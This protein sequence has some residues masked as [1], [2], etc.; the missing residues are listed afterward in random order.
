MRWLDS[1]AYK[2]VKLLYKMGSGPIDF[3]ATT[4]LASVWSQV[5]FKLWAKVHWELAL[6]MWILYLIP[7]A[8][9]YYLS[10]QIRD[11]QGKVF[12]VSVMEL[13]PGGSLK[14]AE[15]LKNGSL[16]GILK[17][18]MAYTKKL[19]R[20][21]LLFSL[22]GILDILVTIYLYKGGIIAKNC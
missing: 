13:P 5:G 10:S 12:S 19:F 17:V 6:L 9:G 1:L 7:V 22:F 14:Y 18:N 3:I 8:S 2:I 15:N 16:K 21:F 20:I 4:F 11:L